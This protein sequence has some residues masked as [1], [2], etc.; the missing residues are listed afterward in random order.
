[1]SVL[2]IIIPIYN[3][4]KDLR[5]CLD[6]L[7]RQTSPSYEVLLIDDGSTDESGCVC[8]EYAAKNSRFVVYHQE[9]AGV[10]AARNK[11]IELASGD[12]IG[13]IDPDDWVSNH[14]VETAIRESGNADVLCFSSAWHFE[15]GATRQYGLE[16]VHVTT[17]NE[18]ETHLLHLRNNQFGRNLLGFNWNKVFRREIVEKY[19]L[20]FVEGLDIS[21]DEVFTLSYCLRAKSL[22]IITDTLYHYVRKTNGLTFKHKRPETIFLLS[23]AL[24]PL[25]CL[26]ETMTMKDYYNYWIRELLLSSAEIASPKESIKYYWKAFVYGYKNDVKHA[27]RREIRTIANRIL[28]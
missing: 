3:I 18:L 10:S 13:F 1:M 2:S 26:M 14:Y 9:N 4:E 15:D 19:S 8:D 24:S 16:A 6:S 12:L 23:N 11:G 28:K 25:V 21:E 5:R 20:R 7:L 22:R 27:T 17:R